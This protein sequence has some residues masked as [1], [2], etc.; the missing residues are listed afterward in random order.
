MSKYLMWGGLLIFLSWVL[1][2]IHNN[3]E[4]AS[5]PKVKPCSD[6]GEWF[7]KDILV[8]CL[9]YWSNRDGGE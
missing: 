1:V 5:R 9:S 3:D 8:R 6:Y 7:V 4:V 2:R